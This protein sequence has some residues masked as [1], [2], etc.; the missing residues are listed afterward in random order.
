MVDSETQQGL[1]RSDD[2]GDTW[3]LV[4]DDANITA[5]PFY[6]YHLHSNPQNAD[7]LW[8]PGNKLWRSTDAGETWM[9]EPGI[10]D[11]F[12]D[13]WIDPNKLSAYGLAITDVVQAIGA[14]NVEIPGGRIELQGIR[15]LQ[16][17]S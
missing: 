2:L 6:F 9:L 14:Q 4:S 3:R 5:R 1:Y 17:G 13:I 7:E 12:Q 16:P 8:V 10:K 15:F 11:D